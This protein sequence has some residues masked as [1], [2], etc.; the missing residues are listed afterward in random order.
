MYMVFGVL[1]RISNGNTRRVSLSGFLHSFLNFIPLRGQRELLDNDPRIMFIPLLS[2]SQI[3]FWKGNSYQCL[4][5]CRSPEDMLEAGFQ[6][7]S[8]NGGA[9]LVNNDWFCELP[10]DD[11]SVLSAFES[12]R[13]LL[14]IVVPFLAS[15][16][17]DIIK[18]FKGALCKKFFALS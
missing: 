17:V 8:T 6:N 11:P 5:I 7:V 12:F 10:T 18:S 16:Q 9:G 2:P 3:L 4:I 1:K 15:K 13:Q 14:L